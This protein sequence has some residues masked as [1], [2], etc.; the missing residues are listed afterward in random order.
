[1]N[2]TL[3]RRVAL[4]LPPRLSQRASTRLVPAPVWR[5][6]PFDRTSSMVEGTSGSSTLVVA[7]VLWYSR[8]STR[9]LRVLPE[10][11]SHVGLATSGCRRRQVLRL[12]HVSVDD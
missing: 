10:C 2:I 3:S 12:H 4:C 11:C 8:A 1:L 9:A 6:I 5:L 7:M